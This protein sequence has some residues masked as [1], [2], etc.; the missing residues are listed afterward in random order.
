MVPSARLL[1]VLVAIMALQE[2]NAGI[3]DFF[4]GVDM[5]ITNKLPGRV[6]LRVHCKSKDD[7][8][9]F[10][11][12]GPNQTWGF[13]FVPTAFT[14]FYCSMQ[15][16]GH[17]HYFDIYGGD[18]LKGTASNHKTWIIRPGGPCI[19]RILN[20]YWGYECMKWNSWWPALSTKNLYDCYIAP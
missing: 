8:L 16:P 14:L 15:W 17:F 1:L 4:F 2:A 11:N 3:I 19:R 5:R 6:T 18:N 13:K 20:G 7:D 9:G 10:Q 12:I